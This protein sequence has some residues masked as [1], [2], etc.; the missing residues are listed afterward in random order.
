MSTQINGLKLG[1]I[2]IDKA[3][4]VME[5]GKETSQGQK[6]RKEILTPGMFDP[7]QSFRREHIVGWVCYFGMFAFGIAFWCFC[8]WLHHKIIS[9]VVDR[10]I[11]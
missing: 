1:T 4:E 3:E 5:N 10:S 11:F 2:W 6:G 7:A 9:N 8:F